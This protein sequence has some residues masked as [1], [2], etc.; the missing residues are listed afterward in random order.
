MILGSILSN[1]S[2]GISGAAA[3]GKNVATSTDWHQLLGGKHEHNAAINAHY[4]QLKSEGAKMTGAKAFIRKSWDN[5][6]AA[7]YKGQGV[8]RAGVIGVRQAAGIATA[9]PIE[10]AIRYATGSG[11][12]TEKDGK[13][14]IAGIPFI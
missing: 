6:I 14:D 10:G 13:K 1:M 4:A 7:D 5:Q 11:T 8:K 12:F 3:K 9:I 2:S